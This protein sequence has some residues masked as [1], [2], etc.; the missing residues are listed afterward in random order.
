[1]DGPLHLIGTAERNAFLRRDDQSEPS[2]VVPGRAKS[3]WKD[4][5]GALSF[6]GAA[7]K[8]DGSD[9]MALAKSRYK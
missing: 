3:D 2:Y 9:G 7:R 8:Q 6:I 1:M 4:A 5:D